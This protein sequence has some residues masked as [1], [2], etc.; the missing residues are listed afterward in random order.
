MIYIIKIAGK[1]VYPNDI[2]GEFTPGSTETKVLTKLAEDETIHRYNSIKQLK[3]EVLLR[4]NIIKASLELARS[5][6]KFKIFTDSFCNPEFWDR[7]RIGGF[8]VKQG[9]S[10]YDA[11]SDIYKN[12]PKYGTECSTAIIILYY[13]ALIKV[14]PKELFDIAF[15]GLQLY[16]WKFIDSDLGINTR[17]YASRDI[18]G[19]CRYFE[20][21]EFNPETPEWRGENAIDLGNGKFYGHGIGIN[22]ADEIVEKLNRHK[23]HPSAPSAFLNN[24]VTNPNYKHLFELYDRFRG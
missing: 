1:T 2:I 11:I 14:Y 7:T 16:N 15:S 5:G 23:A 13:G 22:T 20:N 21:P 6:F 19:D 9:V 18:P 10:P 24:S 3:F 12:G 4:T 8:A 17:L